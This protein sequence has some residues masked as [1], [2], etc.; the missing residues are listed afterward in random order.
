MHWAE[1]YHG[2]PYAPGAQGP[3]AYNCWGL[4]R[5]IERDEFGRGMPQLA[6]EVDDLTPRA[7]IRLIREHPGRAGWVEVA[8]PADGDLVAM[9]RLHDEAHIGVWAELDGGAVIHAV[10]G[11]GVCKHSILHVRLMGYG[12][13]RT[14]RPA[15]EIAAESLSPA[16]A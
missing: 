5:A 2:K 16:A 11:M 13:V 9:G 7:L 3:A 14:Y 8:R 12:L 15:I 10:A 4:A 6:V 1:K